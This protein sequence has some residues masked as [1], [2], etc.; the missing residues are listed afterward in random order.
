VKTVRAELVT[1][2]E[3]VTAEI[4]WPARRIARLKRRH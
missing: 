2:R 3:R 1:V 4:T